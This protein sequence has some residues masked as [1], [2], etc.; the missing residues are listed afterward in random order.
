MIIRCAIRTLVLFVVISLVSSH[1]RMSVPC[2]SIPVICVGDH[3]CLQYYYY[4]DPHCFDD[5]FMDDQV[6]KRFSDKRAPSKLWNI[7]TGLN[8]IPTGKKK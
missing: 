2:E 8:R 6:E 7:L 1:L 3:R 4:E 5:V